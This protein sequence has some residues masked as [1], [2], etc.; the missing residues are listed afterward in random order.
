M[1]VNRKPLV[2]MTGIAKH[3]PGVKALDGVNFTLE[4]GKYMCCSARTARASP[5]SSRSWRA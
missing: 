5:P 3:Y 1:S 4:A 2:E